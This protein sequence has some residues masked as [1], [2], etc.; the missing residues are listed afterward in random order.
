MSA[1]VKPK[2][3]QVTAKCVVAESA[4]PQGIKLQHFYRHAMLPPDVP[5]RKIDLLLRRRMIVEVTI[6]A[7]GH[8]TPVRPDEPAAGTA[9]PAPRAGRAAAAKTG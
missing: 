4:T 7:G 1:D 9:T 6:D 5:Q 3:Y 8:A 2:R